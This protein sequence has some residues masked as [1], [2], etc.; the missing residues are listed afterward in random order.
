MPFHIGLELVPLGMGNMKMDVVS[1][2]ALAL[3][4]TI[5]CGNPIGH[6]TL[7]PRLVTA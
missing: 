7:F 1:G 5:I 4:K 6:R 3:H 2:P